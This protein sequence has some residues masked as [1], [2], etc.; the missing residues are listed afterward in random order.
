MASH[1]STTFPAATVVVEPCSTKYEVGA[2]TAQP[3]C[4]KTKRTWATAAG[5]STGRDGYKFGDCTRSLFGCLK[6]DRGWKDAAGRDGGREGYEFGDLTRVALSN[7]FG[8]KHRSGA[9]GDAMPRPDPL[10][11]SISELGLG[12]DASL[13]DGVWLGFFNASYAVGR[14]AL[15]S[16]EISLASIEDAEPAVL[17]GIPSLASIECA[18]RSIAVAKDGYLIGFD[19]RKINRTAL[20]AAA[21]VDRSRGNAKAAQEAI[22]L[23]DTMLELAQRVAAS[24]LSCP[25][26]ALLRSRALAMSGTDERV[27]GVDA[28]EEAEINGLVA[29]S[30]S[31]A[32]RTSQM[33]DY[34]RTFG[35]V[36][37]ALMSEGRHEEDMLKMI[38]TLGETTRP[39]GKATSRKGRV[40]EA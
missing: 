3:T 25:G 40:S 9:G 11:G 19:G 32:T 17:L 2:W 8:D 24:R 1:P 28:E 18:I 27:G 37:E 33:P 34:K 7:L 38:G 5:R 29:L 16:F 35:K 15:G 10:F 14:L 39:K 12:H 22:A 26:L 13:L 20:K 6:A 4:E 21:L 23:F 30:Q 31:V 36:L